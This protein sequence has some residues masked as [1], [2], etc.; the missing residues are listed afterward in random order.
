MWVSV[1]PVLVPVLVP[2]VGGECCRGVLLKKMHRFNA[3]CNIPV[4]GAR[5][6]ILIY[7]LCFNMMAG[8]AKKKA[9]P[10]GVA[11]LI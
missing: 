2:V 1:V 9:N 3:V 7:L 5:L 8:G 6:I 11:V 10:F 4:E